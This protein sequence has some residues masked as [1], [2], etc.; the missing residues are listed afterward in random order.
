M[1]TGRNQGE[2]AGHRDVGKSGE[3]NTGR[4]SGG[5]NPRGIDLDNYGPYTEGWQRLQRHRAG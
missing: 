2:R 3:C 1:A 5:I 4:V